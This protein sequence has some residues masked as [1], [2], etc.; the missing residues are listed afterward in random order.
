MKNPS[1][2]LPS[3]KSFLPSK[4]L[5]RATRPP[6]DGFHPRSRPLFVDGA[7]AL[8]NSNCARV[9]SARFRPE[10]RPASAAFPLRFVATVAF[11]AFP[12]RNRQENSVSESGPPDRGTQIRKTMEYIR[13]E[14]DKDLGKVQTSAKTLLDWHYYIRNY[15]WACLGGAALIGYLMVPRKLEIKAPD[16]ETLEK[17]ARKHHLVVESKPKAEKKSGLLAGAFSFLS[18]LVMKTAMVHVGNQLAEMMQ[19]MPQAPGGSKAAPSA[20]PKSRRPLLPGVR[21]KFAQKRRKC[22]TMQHSETNP[23][24][25]KPVAGVAARN[26]RALRQSA[27]GRECKQPIP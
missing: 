22:R 16:A 3:K 19:G 1:Q 17:L 10:R 12:L 13:G 24:R 21:T 11:V 18:G 6:R 27:R 15:P 14:L 9:K 26:R 2:Y 25:E 5:R 20:A 23:W 4:I 7:I 8:P